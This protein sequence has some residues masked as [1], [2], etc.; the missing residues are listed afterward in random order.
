MPR[1]S[2]QITQNSTQRDNE[3]HYDTIPVDLAARSR[4]S[5][6]ATSAPVSRPSNALSAL[7]S[8]SP[9][10]RGEP[11]TRV[12]S[13]QH[14][15]NNP[16]R[17]NENRQRSNRPQSSSNVSHVNEVRERSQQFYRQYGGRNQRQRVV[18]TNPGTS[19]L[20]KHAHAIN[21]DFFFK[22]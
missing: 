8:P 5:G 11:S 10:R 12:T 15:G 21:R 18:T 20:R 3:N 17:R 6:G 16:E 19:T 7:Q 14:R 2:A 22:L 13:H 9:E 4:T 1:N